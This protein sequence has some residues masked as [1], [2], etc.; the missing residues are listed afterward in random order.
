M[1]DEELNKYREAGKIIAEIREWSKS[2]VKPGTRIEDIADKIEAK[3][4]E[5]AGIAFPVNVSL[6]HVAAHY[7]PKF[8]DETV[9]K[10]DDLVTI[11]LGAHVDGYISDT[12]YTIDL[13]GENEELVAA[14]VDGLQ[15]AIDTVAAGVKVAD[16][17]T[18]I[19]GAI[20]EHGFRPIENLTGHQLE[21]YVLHAGGAIP[22]INVPY[23][24]ELEEGQ[25]FAIEPFATNGAGRV[26]ETPVTQIYSFIQNR[27]TRM[28]EGKILLQEVEARKTLPFAERW[29]A[30]KMNPLKLRMVIKELVTRDALHGYAALQDA[31][32]GL[33]SQAEHTVIVTDNGCEVTTK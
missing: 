28:R 11:D 18:A 3:I 33:V 20:R 24:W 30:R 8:K 5:K 4:S 12:A 19:E 2:L 25:V 22:N 15:A 23:D 6:N 26:I 32:K 14:S 1:N 21:Q 13:S 10:D 29:F 31:D 7:A 9:L 27:P 16:I 17:G